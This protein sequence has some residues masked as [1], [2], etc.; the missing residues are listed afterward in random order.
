MK[1]YY[2][3]LF[4][5][6][7]SLVMESADEQNTVQMNGLT[8]DIAINEI[9]I[10]Q[11][12]KGYPKW[13]ELICLSKEKINLKGWSLNDSSNCFFKFKED[14][15]LEPQQLLMICFYEGK[16]PSPESPTFSKNISKDVKHVINVYNSAPFANFGEFEMKNE[17]FLKEWAEFMEK[18]GKDAAE[19]EIKDLTGPMYEW[20]Q[21]EALKYMKKKNY[22]E[23]YKYA[24]MS[25]MT[26][27]PREFDEVALLDNNNKLISYI[28]W[29]NKANIKSEKKIKWEEEARVLGDYDRVQS[30]SGQAKPNNNIIFKGNYKGRFKYKF[31]RKGTHIIDN[32]SNS[33]AK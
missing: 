32:T 30:L 9:C 2:L 23:K 8:S 19:K 26:T 16:D 33:S 11:T 13:I 5:L 10:K 24:V 7:F 31:V 27:S 22:P 3:S 28:N 20:Y 14:L 12:T 29:G 1:S 4:L 6:C 17:A 18:L 21:E 15:Y 25:L